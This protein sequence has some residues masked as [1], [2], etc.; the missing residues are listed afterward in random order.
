MAML[1]AA[2]ALSLVLVLPAKV[3]FAA[4]LLPVSLA[5]SLVVLRLVGSFIHAFLPVSSWC[6]AGIQ[7]V[8]TLFRTCFPGS[9]W[10]N[11]GLFV[12]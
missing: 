8:E 11:S 10:I 5:L 1:A 4:P 2:L 6:S 7:V 12:T 3:A 9:G